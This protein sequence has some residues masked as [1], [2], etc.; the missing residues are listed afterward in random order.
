MS[1]IQVGKKDLI[2]VYTS[3]FLS[4]GI[5]ILLLPLIMKFLRDEELGLWYVFA[6]ISQVVSLFDFGFNATISRHM[7]YAWSGASKLEKN[8]VSDSYNNG[9]NSTLVSEIIVTCR[10]VYLIISCIS[11]LIMATLGTLYIYK[12]V[13]TNMTD[14]ILVAWIIY[15][16]SV[17]INMFYGYWSSLLQGIGAISERNRMGIYS[18]LSQILVATILIL[19]GFGL[20]GFVISY[21]ISGCVLR[22]AGKIYFTKKTKEIEINKKIS[23][24]SIR[25][26]FSAVWSTAWKDGIVMISQY[27]ATQANTLI[28]A[29]YIDLAS[30]S[31]YGVMTQVVSIIASIAA[32]YFNAYQPVFSGACLER[33]VEKQKQIVCTTN[34]I[35]KSLFILGVVALFLLGIPL[36]KILRP[37]MKIDILFVVLLC[38][39]YYFFNQKDLFA[40]MISSFNVIPYWRAYVISAFASLFLS[41]VFVKIFQMGIIGLV[42]AQI[43]INVLYNYWKWPIYIMN[44]IGIKYKEIYKIGYIYIKSRFFKK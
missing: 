2:W 1:R 42:L 36:I 13:N 26:C 39:F 12:V 43:I 27:I 31:L 21:F 15:M 6:S 22:I 11:L 17:F 7:T 5:N 35:Y 3:R 18:K 37:G 38:L 28:C 9:I 40:S 34:F 33:N 24:S 29:Y 32:S 14:T 44:R 25:N 16:I 19:L 23:F 20:V 10:F 30:T 8:S 4:I 41:I